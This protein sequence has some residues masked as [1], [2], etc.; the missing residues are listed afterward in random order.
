MIAGT[1][2][3]PDIKCTCGRSVIKTGDCTRTGKVNYAAGA[4]GNAG[5]CTCPIEIKCASVSKIGKNG[6]NCARTGDS[7]DS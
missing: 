2:G 4:V 1:G 5:N 3:A 7:H 6:G